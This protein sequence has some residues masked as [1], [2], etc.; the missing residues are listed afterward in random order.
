VEIKQIWEVRYN[1]SPTLTRSE[2][3]AGYS[4]E[5]TNGTTYVTKI[6]SKHVI[7]EEKRIKSKLVQKVYPHQEVLNDQQI[8]RNILLKRMVV[9]GSFSM[10]KVEPRFVLKNQQELENEGFRFTT[11]LVAVLEQNYS[12]LQVENDYLS[13]CEHFWRTGFKGVFNEFEEEILFISDW[14]EKS[15]V[16]QQPVQSFMLLWVAFNCIYDTFTEKTKLVMSNDSF[17]KI[18]KSVE[19]LLKES[20]IKSILR[21][22]QHELSS[23]ISFNLIV[24][25]KNGQTKDTPIS[26]Q[27]NRMLEENVPS[28]IILCKSMRCIYEIRNNVFHQGSLNVNIEHQA[29]VAK[30]LLLPITTKMLHNIILY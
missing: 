12:I 19:K 13:T 6:Y 28:N 3:F 5:V 11:P 24:P 8:I 23:L 29:L 30:S 20:D 26:N 14:I 2:E 16:E 15:F 10:I 17:N 18:K 22:H 4:F 1:V 21:N 25:Q 9:T 7:L 27:L